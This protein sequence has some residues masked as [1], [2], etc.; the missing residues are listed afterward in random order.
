M[1]QFAS[2]TDFCSFSGEKL[3]LGFNGIRSQQA[4]ITKVVDIVF[5]G[6][7]QT[8]IYHFHTRPFVKNDFNIGSRLKKI[9]PQ[10]DPVASL[11]SQCSD[12]EN[13]SGQD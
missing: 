9:Y 1:I 12:V 4:V 8:H 5:S 2:F 10:L 11:T 13:T 3:N 7:Y 6:F